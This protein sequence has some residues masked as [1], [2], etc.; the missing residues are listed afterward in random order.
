MPHEPRS[1]MPRHIEFRHDANSTVPSVRDQIA[2]FILRVVKGVGAQFMELWRFLALHAKALG[3]REVP[4]ENVH[5]HGF[6]TVD[7]PTADIEGHAMTVAHDH[8]HSPWETTLVC[9]P[10]DRPF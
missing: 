9:N 3:L 4:M 10:N 5:L 6:H 7:I 1:A 8:R 2:N